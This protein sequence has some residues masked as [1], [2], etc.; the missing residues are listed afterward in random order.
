[1]SLCLEV[2]NLNLRLKNE[3]IINNI[4]FALEYGKT[5]AIVGE[6]GAGKSMIAKAIIQCLPNSAKVAKNSSIKLN[7]VELIGLSEREMCQIRG[8]EIGLIFQDAMAALNPVKLIGQQLAEVLELHSE[9]PKHLIQEKVIGLLADVDI[10]EPEACYKSYP[11]QLS[12]GMLQRA[13]IAS[14][15][16]AEPRLIIADEPTTALDVTVQAKLMRLLSQLQSKYHCGLI[17]ISHDLLLVREIADYIMVLKSGNCVEFAEAEQF[18]AAPEATYSEQLL[19]S[20]IP[21]NQHLIATPARVMLEVQALTVKFAKPR[22]NIFSAVDYLLAVNQ[23]SFKIHEGHTMALIGE[24]GSGKT[25]IAKAILGIYPRLGK[26]YWH[27]SLNPKTDIAVVFQNPFSSMNPRMTVKDVL[28]EL[29]VAK[30][31]LR[32]KNWQEVLISA[33]ADV[34]LP[35]DSLDKY[36]HQFSGGERQRLCI[37]RAIVGRPKVIILDEPTSA[38]DV[39]I[40]VMIAELF[41]R[42]Q[43]KYGYSYLLI[44]HDFA[45]V[46]KMAHNV[47]VMRQGKIVE[48]GDVMSI[49]HSPQ[50]VYTQELLQSVPGAEEI[51]A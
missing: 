24:S 3:L 13:L 34:G 37:A 42:L 50:H 11:H 6:S 27:A 21:T 32:P 19:M 4:S 43:Q 18:F 22:K 31:K 47:A 9:L 2:N 44:T 8:K 46:K 51:M 14:V 1:M 17:F 41:I 39:S 28:T 23:A 49:L 38:L 40:Q 30:P 7:E 35:A 5:L 15:L 12:G 10:H 16:V 25:S 26:I 45:V 20:A 36:P 33:L 29:W 48:Q